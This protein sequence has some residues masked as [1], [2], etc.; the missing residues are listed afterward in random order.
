MKEG[1]DTMEKIVM[2]G[3]VYPY[4]GGISHYTGLMYKALQKKYDVKMISYKLQY[5]KFLFKKEQRDYANDS[6]KIEPTHYWINTANPFNWIISAKKIKKEKP[7][8]VII[9][10]WHPY[11]A[12]CYYMLAKMLKKIKIIFVCHNVFPHERFPMDRFLSKITL[13]QGNAYIVQSKSDAQDLEAIIPN[14]TYE[15]TVHPTYNAFKFENMSM[16][17]ARNLLHIDQDERILLFFGFVRDY[18]GLKFLINALPDIKEKIS[19]IKLLIVGD[20]DGDKEDYLNL[21]AENM[22]ENSIEIIDG[23]IPDKQVEKYFAA[24]NLVVLPYESATQSG[25][26]QIAYGFEKPVVVTNVGGLPDVVDDGKTGYVVD[27]KNPKKIAE[28]IQKFFIE[29][30]EQEMIN[31]VKKEDYRFSWERMVEVVDRLNGKANKCNYSNI[32]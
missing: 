13:K 25:I 15:Q 9:Q 32:Q 2:I 5:P 20:F 30:V 1:K 26:V 10:W 6:F 23:Y 4:K 8:L 3:P 24:C 16:D 21:I 18:K 19:N 7:D 27:K 17:K 14:A 28:A 31:N 11:F 29:N 12:P 22:V